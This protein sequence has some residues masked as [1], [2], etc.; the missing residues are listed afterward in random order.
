MKNGYKPALNKKYGD[1]LKNT[2]ELLKNYFSKIMEHTASPSNEHPDTDENRLRK[3]RR[4]ELLEIIL[5]LQKSEQ[6]LQEENQS[7][8]E[9]LDKINEKMAIRRQLLKEDKKLGVAVK[10][11]E[12]TYSMFRNSADQYYILLEEL[13]ADIAEKMPLIRGRTIYENKQN[14]QCA[15]H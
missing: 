15:K 7:L 14:R 5:M 9:Q 10:Q 11:M 2:I 13:G 6:S 12:N 3:L 4:T 8:K 1:K